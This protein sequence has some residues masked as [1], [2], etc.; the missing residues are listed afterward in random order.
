MSPK[1]ALAPTGEGEHLP[2]LRDEA[3]VWPTKELAGEHAVV[4]VGIAPKGRAWH[5]SIADSVW[6]ID[7]AMAAIVMPPEVAL[8]P[9]P[10]GLAVLLTI[11]AIGLLLHLRGETPA[12]PRKELADELAVVWV[13][14]TPPVGAWHA[15]IADHGDAI[16]GYA[17]AVVVPPEIALAPVHSLL[18]TILAIGLLLDLRGESPA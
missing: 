10:P 16:D 6:A 9:V 17:I 12:W 14:I 15:G 11:L 13:G 18:L 3:P 8:A 4:W 5:A 1:V 7:L 2:D